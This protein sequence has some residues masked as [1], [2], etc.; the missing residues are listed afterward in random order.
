MI[1]GERKKGLP[2]TNDKKWGER[3][4]VKS[5]VST[6]KNIVSP[7]ASCPVAPKDIS[8]IVFW[9]I[10]ATTESLNFL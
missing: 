3:V 4:S 9:I 8:H 10:S 7:L 1:L 5:N 6:Q 2:Q